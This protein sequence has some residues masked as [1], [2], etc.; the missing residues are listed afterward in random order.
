M[1]AGRKNYA[2]TLTTG[3]Q[4]IVLTA[5]GK[6]YA[7]KLLDLIHQHWRIGGGGANGQDNAGATETTLTNVLGNFNGECYECGV[8]GHR[9]HQCIAE[10]TSNG[11]C[12]GCDGGGGHGGC[13]GH[14]GNKTRFQ[15]TC[16]Y[17]HKKGHKE[18]ACW[19]KDSNARSRPKNYK[20][21]KDKEAGAASVEVLVLMVETPE[22]FG[23][24]FLLNSVKMPSDEKGEKDQKMVIP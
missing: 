16:N 22:G 13:G 5:G 12:G 8:K 23:E 6:P 11:G 18:D 4:T 24:E 10:G 17:C 2:S 1:R 3:T 21:A 7:K 14:G 19:E 20:T 15:E 9:A